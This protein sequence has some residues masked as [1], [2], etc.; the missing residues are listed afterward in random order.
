MTNR[1][2]NFSLPPISMVLLDEVECDLDREIEELVAT[3]DCLGWRQ[4]DSHTVQEI[5][6]LRVMRDEFESYR[7]EW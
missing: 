6:K 2:C 1:F 3:Q 7:L 5:E 4:T